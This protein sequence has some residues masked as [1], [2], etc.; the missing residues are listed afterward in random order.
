MRYRV[1]QMSE[2]C[3]LAQCKTS[4]LFRWENIDRTDNFTWIYDVSNAIHPS[5]ETAKQSIKRYRLYYENKKQYP[6]YYKA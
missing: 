1:K 5:L 6:K 2:N 3:F 4:F